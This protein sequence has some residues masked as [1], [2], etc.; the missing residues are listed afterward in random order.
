MPSFTVR[1]YEPRDQEGFGHVRSRVYRGG[2]PV[3]PHEQLLRADST[4]FVVEADGQIV[5]AATALDMTCSRDGELHRCAG[6]AA[7]AVLPE[8]RGSGAGSALMRGTLPLL[9]EAGYKVSSLHPFRDS[10]YRRFGFVGVGM[11]LQIR[12]PADRL[13]TVCAELPVVEIAPDRRELL[14]PVCAHFARSYNGYNV[15]SPDQ[16]WRTLGGDTPMAIYVCGDPVEAYAIVR[17][18]GDFWIDQDVREFLWTTDRGYR[19]MLAFFRSLA[20]NKSAVTWMEPGNSP[21]VERYYERGASVELLGPVMFRRLDVDDEPAEAT[22]A[23]L[24]DPKF[25]YCTDAF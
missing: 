4:G 22:R 14:D 20:M 18:K 2:D 16:W 10:W 5:G 9:R 8:W 3:F 19:T 1:A 17:L 15:R 24:G 23:W 6:I 13:P 7:V 11:R 12:C 25:V 21:Y